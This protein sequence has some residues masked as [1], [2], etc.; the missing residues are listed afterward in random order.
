MLVRLVRLPKWGFRQGRA[1]S[2]LTISVSHCR[3]VC[4][5]RGEGGDDD[6]V[7]ILARI[8]LNTDRPAIKPLRY[9]VDRA[10]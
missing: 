9:R 7:C 3:G 2:C 8:A 6:G 4:P 5:L 10:T 1:A